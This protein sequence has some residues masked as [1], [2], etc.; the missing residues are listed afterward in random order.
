MA[1]VREGTPEMSNSALLQP[2]SVDEQRRRRHSRRRAR[3]VAAR[4]A[5][6]AMLFLGRWLKAP[7]RIGAMAPS[8]RY[9]ARAMAQ[10]IDP[11]RDRLVIELGGGTGSIT[12]ALLQSGLPPERLLVVE[13]D[14]RLYRL[15]RWRFP[16]LRVLR[17]DAAHLVEL[18]RPLGITSASAVVSSLPLL[19]MPRTLRREIVD[20]SFRLLGERGALIQYTYGPSSP[21]AGPEYGVAGRIA[22]RVWLNFPPAAVWRFERAANPAMARVA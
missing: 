17:G 21:L 9:L 16:Q 11:R 6:E 15:L 19:S 3:L 5:D 4:P 10:E 18:V 7:H 13:R 8:S 14:R 2:R 1:S 20:Q 12:R 22:S